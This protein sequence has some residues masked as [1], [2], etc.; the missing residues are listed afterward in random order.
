MADAEDAVSDH[1]SPHRHQHV[2]NA[3]PDTQPNEA[4]KLPPS[5]LGY[6]CNIFIF[7]TPNPIPTA[8]SPSA[9]EP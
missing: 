5:I 1:I 7:H 8:C 4:P 3:I 6:S 2:L 9:C